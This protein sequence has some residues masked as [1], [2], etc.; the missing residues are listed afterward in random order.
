MAN[1]I[2]I[3]HAAL[4]E[5][6]ADDAATPG[7]YLAMYADDATGRMFARFHAEADRLLG[8][9]ERKSR[10]EGRHYNAD[11]S[12]DLLQLM[13][14][15]LDA[16]RVMKEA[17]RPFDISPA[18]SQVLKHCWG[19]LQE[20]QGSAIPDDLPPISID[21]YSP[22]FT[23]VDRPGTSLVVER[24]RLRMVGGGSY[25]IVWE[26]V[27]PNYGTKF[28]LKRIKSDS[29]VELTRF[30]REYELMRQMDS[31]HVLRVYSYDDN[32]NEYTMEHC[33]A[34]LRDFI[35]RNNAR[36]SFEQRREIALQFLRGL[37]HIHKR[38]V[39]HRDLSPGN[40]LV[41]EYADL[42]V[43]VK[44]ADFGLA[45]AADS[46]LTRTH[47][48]VKGT[49][50]DPSLETF[51]DYDI[52]Y[53]MYPVGHLLGFIFSGRTDPFR[54]SEDLLPIVRRCLDHDRSL[55]YASI[56]ELIAEIAAV[57]RT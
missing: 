26:Y 6:H 36:L 33:T 45:K 49:I 24:Q 12:R 5:R 39:L 22:I 15:V 56:T 31:P 19:F 51:R 4:A 7:S 28:A 17:G 29:G 27:D 16:H 52:S 20:T 2:E 11:E 18:Y 40:V 42:G 35:N 34:T 10:T 46:D 13:R 41:K 3:M 43:L 23:L 1:P 14:E 50:V 21:R 25:G 9:L 30:R 57:S 55:R 47:S 44:I 54:V 32:L 8:F 37:E 38:D 53:E 48:A